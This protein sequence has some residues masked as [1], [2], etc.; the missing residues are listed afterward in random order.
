MAEGRN[1]FQLRH[2]TAAPTAIQLE[3]YELGYSKNESAL[4]IGLLNN[5]VRSVKKIIDNRLPVLETAGV[6]IS[7]LQSGGSD[8]KLEIESKVEYSRIHS[9]DQQSGEPQLNING[10]FDVQTL[11]KWTGGHTTANSIKSNLKYLDKI[12]LCNTNNQD[13]GAAGGPAYG[14][15]DPWEDII[16]N[17]VEG[18][19]YFKLVIE[20]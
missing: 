13:Q 7:K 12:V 18:Q 19:L 14:I 10:L 8:Y 17:P 16:E 2:G 1:I 20:E 3:P 6:L 5:N 15:D 11:I 4:Y 9:F